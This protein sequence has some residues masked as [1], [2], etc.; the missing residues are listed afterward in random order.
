MLLEKCILEAEHL[1]RGLIW[2][3]R[4]APSDR[5]HNL[6]W[7]LHASVP[8]TDHVRAFLFSPLI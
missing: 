6:R 5:S 4:R 7:K 8:S 1:S 3:E 2:Y